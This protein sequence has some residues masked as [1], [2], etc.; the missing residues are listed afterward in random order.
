MS[1]HNTSSTKEGDESI[2]DVIQVLK[3][4]G[5]GGDNQA[6]EYEDSEE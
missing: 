1:S 4:S 5:L 6:G 2:S 3:S